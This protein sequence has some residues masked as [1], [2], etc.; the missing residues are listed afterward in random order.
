[1]GSKGLRLVINGKKCSYSDFRNPHLNTYAAI[2]V[3][4]CEAGRARF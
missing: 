4:S 3:E 2:Y 1:M